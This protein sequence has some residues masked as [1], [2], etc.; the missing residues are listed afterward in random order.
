MRR[1]LNMPEPM[2]EMMSRMNPVVGIA[3]LV[4]PA[5]ALSVKPV[6]AG[7]GVSSHFRRHYY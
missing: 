4:H 5:T 6:A 3:D 1:Q 2:T 7:S